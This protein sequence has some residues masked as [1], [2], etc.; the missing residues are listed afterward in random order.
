MWLNT[1]GLTGWMCAMCD[2]TFA[3]EY[4]LRNHFVNERLLCQDLW[5]WK[6]RKFLDEIKGFNRGTRMAQEIWTNLHLQGM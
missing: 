5:T 4:K 2:L 3:N 1:I 6:R